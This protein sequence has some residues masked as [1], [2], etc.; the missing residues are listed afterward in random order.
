[1]IR[2]GTEYYVTETATRGLETDKELYALNHQA[3]PM[4]PLF[5]LSTHDTYSR[6]DFPIKM[7]GVLVGNF[8]KNP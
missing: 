5:T 7:T 4:L 8:E 2:M 1:M 3:V 6:G